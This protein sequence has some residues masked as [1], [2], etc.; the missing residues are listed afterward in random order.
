MR[1]SI[2]IASSDSSICNTVLSAI[3]T[4][5]SAYTVAGIASVGPSL[6]HLMEE[7]RPS[8]VIVDC[9][10]PGVDSF[11]AIRQIKA[12]FGYNIQIIAVG[13]RTFDAVFQS[14]KAGAND[15]L[16]L[17]L[18]RDE[19]LTSLAQ[20]SESME[21]LLNKDSASRRFYLTDN[22][23]G[24]LRNHPLTLEQLNITYGTHFTD[25]LYQMFFIK[26]DFPN[27]FER[28]NADN[29][30]IFLHLNE[31]IT[32]YF[33]EDCADIIY[34]AKNDGVMVL[35]NYTKSAQNSVNSKI[36]DL[37]DRVSALIHS[38]R[39]LDITICVSS[40]VDN[41][42]DVGNL[43][44]QV[45][46]AEWSRM[47]YG[48]NKIIF[49]NPAS[50]AAQ[51]QSTE[52]LEPIIDSVRQ[53]VESLNISKFKMAINEF[54]AL[55][56]S[57]LSSHEARNFIRQVISHLFQIYWDTIAGFTETATCYDDLSYCL[58]LC[59]SFEQHRI[60]LITQCVDLM[61]RISAQSSQKYSPAVVQAISYVKS[62][63]DQ[64]ISLE[65]AAAEVQLSKGYFSFLFKKEMGVNFTKYVNQHKN[66]V[67]CEL[68]KTSNLNISEIAYRVGITDVRAF[69]KKFHAMNGTTPSQY[70]KLHR[71]EHQSVL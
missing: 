44:T 69:S 54:Y 40:L 58:H 59:T 24:G 10:S 49:W 36:L 61:E 67:A 8:I 71:V 51:A 26:F 65:D 12:A 56:P 11:E 60:T 25:G 2:I 66:T 37:Y 27:S 46:D 35:L 68:L 18:D 45:R 9:T 13:S 28:L 5:Q 63:V 14:I 7:N 39:P 57:I 20:L 29:T 16:L 32:K 21:K 6:M 30:P 42:C 15:Y 31:F 64:P 4:S 47:R 23:I 38:F 19:L 62:H 41:A 3:S 1:C 22:S 34:E 53:A 33:Q 50:A 70:K 52:K 48:V 17:P 55:S 43:K